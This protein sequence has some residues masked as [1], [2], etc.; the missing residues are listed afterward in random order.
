[1]IPRSKID[2]ETITQAKR[3]STKISSF[4]VKHIS[5]QWCNVEFKSYDQGRSA[6]EG[7]VRSIWFDEE[8]PE[9]I[10]SECITRTLTGNNIIMIT[11]TPL[12]G[13]SKVI[14]NFINDS[15]YT[16]GPKGPGKYLISQTWNDVPHL[17]EEAKAEALASYPEYQK[18]A[19]SE[20]IPM[21]GQGAVY[22]V[23]E[24]LYTISPLN[25]PIP[26][27]WKR[28]AG[29]DFGFVAPTAIVWAA[30]DP[31][32][33]TYYIYSE[34]YFK[35][36]T[37]IFH[38]DAIKTRNNSAGFDIPI[39][40][41]P[42][43]GGTSM[44]D[45]LQTRLIYEQQYGIKMISAINSIEPGI[46]KVLE[47]FNA[48]KIKIYS[49]CVN[50]LSELRVY[51]RDNKGKPAGADHA[52]DALRYLIMSGFDNSKTKAEF[53]AITSGSFSE[54]YETWNERDIHPDAWLY[55]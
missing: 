21:L 26:P 29:L 44:S 46:T 45:G 40:C 48:G 50:L 2:I 35:E 49:S 18:L 6:F 43:G 37:P 53:D 1:M 4:R 9:D 14:R 11:F 5:G 38:A 16:E 3:T 20:G 47:M 7:T 17:T 39:V 41:D 30:I 42:S 19:R 55:R 33:E 22:P 8:P 24:L 34:H 15:D 25:Y 52:C 12:M 51:Q 10:Y 28:V 13:M 31:E 32:T 23:S 54:T 36:R 27:H